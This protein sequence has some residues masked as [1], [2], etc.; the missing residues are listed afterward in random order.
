MKKYYS[1]I[2]FLLL[3]GFISTDAISQ[4]RIDSNFYAE[5][6]AEFNRLNRESI[7]RSETVCNSSWLKSVTD[8]EVYTRVQSHIFNY[9]SSSSHLYDFIRS[10]TPCDS[11]TGDTSLLLA[12][13][14]EA[15]EGVIIALIKL[16]ANPLIS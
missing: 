13:Y 4:A 1:A 15:D 12:L 6:I 10:N 7:E 16:G 3:V 8:Q 9:P 11:E 5:R 14:A 2:S